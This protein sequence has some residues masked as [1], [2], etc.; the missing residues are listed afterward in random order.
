MLPPPEAK[1]SKF[2][3][4]PWLPVEAALSIFKVK[5]TVNFLKKGLFKTKEIITN[6]ESQA[7]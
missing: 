6:N 1:G 3:Y 4:S 2:M 5:N 7:L